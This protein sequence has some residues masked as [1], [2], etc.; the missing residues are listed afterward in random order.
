MALG[1]LCADEFSVDV[2]YFV[3]PILLPTT[4]C[5]LNGS[6]SW[7]DLTH[8]SHSFLVAPCRDE[9]IL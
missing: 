8:P 2:T 1:E 4:G 6:V 7:I 9:T 3:K 5:D